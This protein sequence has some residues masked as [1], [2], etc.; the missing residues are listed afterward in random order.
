MYIFA[1]GPCNLSYPFNLFY[2]LY[3]YN[4]KVQVFYWDLICWTE[5][6]WNEKDTL[7]LSF[8]PHK[9]N[10]FDLNSFVVAL[11]VRLMSSTKR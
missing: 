9:W 4:H 5:G 7:F 2:M 11:A 8:F 10:H 3:I 6:K 1:K